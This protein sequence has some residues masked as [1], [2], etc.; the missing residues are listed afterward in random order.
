MEAPIVDSAALSCSKEPLRTPMPA[1][2]DE[3]TP[4]E[5]SRDLATAERPWASTRRRSCWR[6]GA[7]STCT[8]TGTRCRDASLLASENAL[9]NEYHLANVE[10]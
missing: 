10:T 5:Q 9:D 2:A 7:L 4:R 1:T 3:T 6:S 8:V